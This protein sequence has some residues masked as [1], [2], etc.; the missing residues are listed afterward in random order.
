MLP[1]INGYARL[2]MLEQ[3]PA[4]GREGLTCDYPVTVSGSHLLL[5]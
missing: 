4:R 3:L 5:T 2:N 1:T